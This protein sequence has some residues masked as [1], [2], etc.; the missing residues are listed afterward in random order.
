LGTITPGDGAIGTLT[1]SSFAWNGGNTLA[2]ELSSIDST[3]DLLSLSGALSKTGT[4]TYA[5]DF[6]GGLAGQTYTLINFGSNSGFSSSDFSVNSGMAGTFALNGASLT[7][8]AVP[9]PHEFALS[10]V[11]LLGLMVFIRRRNLQS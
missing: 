11:G 1:G 6:S 7:F 8:T 9:E 10:I 4:G 5:F 2:F 3:A